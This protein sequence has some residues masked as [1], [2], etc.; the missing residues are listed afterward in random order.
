[1]LGKEIRF[2]EKSRASGGNRENNIALA[3]IICATVLQAHLSE[4]IH[5]G[6]WSYK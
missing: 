3:D 1:M 6:G 4:D 5:Y 2:K